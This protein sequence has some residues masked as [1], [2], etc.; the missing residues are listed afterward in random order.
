MTLLAY[1]AGPMRK[2]P[3]FNFPAFRE[4][5]A[6]LRAMGYTVWSPH[7]RDESTGFYPDGMTGYEDLSE[8]GFDVREAIAV[9]VSWIA[10][11]ADIVVLLPGWEKSLG[12][13]A[14]VA[15]AR[16]LSIPVITYAELVAA[17]S[18]N[19]LV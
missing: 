5:T 6:T 13:A 14:E 15:T 2:I 10:R 7:E 12:V 16:A 1:V 3:E 11:N 8:Y 4:A 19:A 18:A 9:D 17:R